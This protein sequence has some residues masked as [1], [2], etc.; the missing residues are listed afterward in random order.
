MGDTPWH[1]STSRDGGL[2][3]IAIHGFGLR[4]EMIG[5]FRFTFSAATHAE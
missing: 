5:P 1:F 3:S 2:W 4:F